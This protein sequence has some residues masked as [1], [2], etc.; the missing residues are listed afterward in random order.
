MDEFKRNIA[1]DLVKDED[2]NLV[3]I[4]ALK[5]RF[6]DILLEVTLDYDSLT[7]QKIKVDYRKCPSKNCVI[8]QSKIDQLIGTPI[9]KGL[10]KKLYETLGGPQGC[11]N[12]RNMLLCSLPMAINVKAAAGVEEDDIV[13]YKIHENLMGT[14]IGYSEPPE[15]L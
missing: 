6:H 4:N 1:F 3:V 5:D 12:L 14:C 2:N 9:A 8:K 11:T 10:T 13:S 15:M 7:I